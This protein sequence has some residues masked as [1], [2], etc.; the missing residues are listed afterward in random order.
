M[1]RT[2]ANPVLADADVIKWT[3]LTAS[4]VPLPNYHVQI[5]GHIPHQN[6]ASSNLYLVID[7]VAGTFGSIRPSV[8]LPTLY[9]FA[10][11]TF[12]CKKD[13]PVLAHGIHLMVYH[14]ITLV[15]ACTPTSLRSY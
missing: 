12:A 11:V 13:Y 4:M 15:L 1:I 3:D 2:V 6:E 8:H 9:P 5:L 10:L 7:R 14:D